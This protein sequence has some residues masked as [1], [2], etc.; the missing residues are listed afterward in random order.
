MMGEGENILTQAGTKKCTRDRVVFPSTQLAAD[1]A[2]LLHKLIHGKGRQ[3][4]NHT[5]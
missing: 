2:W 4:V 5:P 3:T 1:P